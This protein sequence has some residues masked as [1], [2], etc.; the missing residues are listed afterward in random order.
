MALLGGAAGLG[1]A[2]LAIHILNSAPQSGLPE[3]S[4]DFATAAFAFLITMLCG[5]AFGM[6]P[7]LGSLGFG[8]R[9]A[10][11]KDSRSA[12]AGA[13]LRRVRQALVVAQLGLSL[14]LLVGAGLLSKSFL[15]CRNTD[16]GFR[17][18]N[19][20]SGRLNLSPKYTTPE[21]QVE[22]LQRVLAQASAIPG[23][24]GSGGEWDGVGQCRGQR[25]LPHREPAA[26]AEGGAAGE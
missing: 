24:I 8:V 1:L 5:V 9:E 3:V 20:L 23:V 7:A 12:S 21:A 22:F 19:V 15:K 2:A 13:G 16:P 17:A 6:V 26:R 14:T 4:I 10:L 18:E 11:Q 25:F